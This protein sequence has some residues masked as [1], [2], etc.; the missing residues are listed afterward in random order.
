MLTI[1]AWWVVLGYVPTSV[2]AALM[3]ASSRR[4]QPRHGAPG[5]R[6]DR[7]STWA[8][9]AGLVVDT[10]EVRVARVKI[11]ATAEALIARAARWNE[12]PTLAEIA[13]AEVLADERR[14]AA[15]VFLGIDDVEPVVELGRHEPSAGSV[16]YLDLPTAAVGRA[17]VD[18]HTRIDTAEMHLR[19]GD[20][21]GPM[22]GPP[23]VDEWALP[24]EDGEDPGT[25]R[26]TR[27]R[28][29]RVEAGVT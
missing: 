16:A 18:R 11:E 21:L 9:A 24:D 10:P 23:E 1:I 20:A 5:R 26:H 3:V 12:G 15:E 29:G 22:L 13:A 25:G 7:T 4:Y 28:R 19:F 8:Q 6:R 14:R 27:R 2:T 17:K